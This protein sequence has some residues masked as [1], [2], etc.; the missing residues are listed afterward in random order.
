MRNRQNEEILGRV[1]RF[2]PI[3][4][5][6]AERYVLDPH[7]I[8]AVIAQESGGNPDAVSPKGAKGLMQLMDETA[9]E[10]GL[11]DVTDPQGNIFGG[12]RHLRRLLDRF[13]GNVRLALAAYNAGIGAV[14]R[15]RRIPPYKET[16][17]FVEHVMQY[18][19]IFEQIP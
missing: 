11:S 3:I 10:L 12:T 13:G 4:Q 18:F 14:E 15:Y 9:R 6:A 19:R 7:L 2:N 17:E 16:T 8:Q 5:A 1:R